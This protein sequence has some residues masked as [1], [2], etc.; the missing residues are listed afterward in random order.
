MAGLI[1]LVGVLW[2]KDDSGGFW[3][4]KFALVWLCLSI[5]GPNGDPDGFWKEKPLEF[6]L[7]LSTV[8]FDPKEK[9][10]NLSFEPSV[11]DKTLL[12]IGG[13]TVR[14]SVFPEV[15][16]LLESSS[17]ASPKSMSE[18]FGLVPILG[19]DVS[20][21]LASST[22]CPKAGKLKGVALDGCL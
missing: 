3:K 15:E 2:L 21:T 14:V 4:L 1:V 22:F 11:T 7:A 10:G 6:V 20:K 19:I 17:G 9:I 18:S 13:P 5:F 8:L 12:I 16:A